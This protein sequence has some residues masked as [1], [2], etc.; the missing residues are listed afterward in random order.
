MERIRAPV[1]APAF[2]H[3]MYPLVEPNPVHSRIVSVI[4]VHPSR[5]ELIGIA[6]SL[7]WGPLSRGEKRSKT[8]L[9]QRLESMRDV[10]L[11]FLSTTEGR[12]ALHTSF[13]S[14][15]RDKVATPALASPTPQ[16]AVPPEAT[17]AY[18]LNRSGP[19]QGPILQDA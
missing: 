3:V 14:I 9:V 8:L 18:Y 2:S 13:V 5:S 1:S 12:R 19:W 6:Q 17:L 11:P 7:G 15:R 16:R 4:G 10:L